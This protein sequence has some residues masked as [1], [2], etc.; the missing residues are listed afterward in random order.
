MKNSLM[1]FIAF[2][3]L[4][5]CSKHQE[6]KNIAITGIDSTLRPGDDFFKYVNGKWYDSVQIPASQAGVGV[7]MFMN[8]P[9]RM[10]LQE[11]LDSISQSKNEAGSIAQKVGDFYASGMDTVTIDKRGYTPIKPLLAKI[12]SITDLP[13]LLN[14]VANEEKV[15]NSSIIGFGVSP[16]EKNSSMNIA[17]IYQTGIGLPDRDY[18]FK[19]DSS[20]VAIQKAYKKYLATL[21]QQTGSDAK[22]AEKNANLVYDIDKQLAASHKTKVELRDVQANYNKIAVAALAKRNPNIDWTTFL[23]NLGAKTDSINVGQP[24][25]Y[26]ALNK[27]LKSIPINN[28]KIYLKANSLERYADDLSKS[29]ADASFEYTKVLS[30]QA[31]QKTRG[32]KMANVLDTYLGDALGELY[33]KK[34]FSE[35]AKKRMLVLVNNLQ[36]AY[37][38]RIDKLEWMSPITKQ[39]AK[40]KLA[41]MTKKIGYPD[42]WRDYSNVQVARNTYF[43]NMVSASKDAYQFQLAKLGKPVDKSE[44]FTTVPTVTA[45]NNPTANEIVFPAG[46]LQPPY[47]DNNADD[48]LNYGGIGMVIGHEITHTFDDQGAQYDKDGNLKNWWTKEDYAQFKSR[49]QQVINLYSTY[50]VLG[51]LHING[52]MTVG[53]NTADIAGLAVAY[54]AFKMTEQGKGNTKIDGYTPDQRFFI[55]LAKIWRVKMKDEFLRLWI[56][57]NPH[58]PPNWRVNGP[59]MNTTPFYEAFN[60]KPGD[61]MFLPKKDRITIW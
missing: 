40:E 51:D 9:Q 47:F 23:N 48:A 21:F 14:F 7:Y 26:D 15:S 61:K 4:T 1:L 50:T 29:F 34:Y 46:I 38:K 25:Y 57:N 37:A 39:K 54:D 22:E 45:Y 16:D 53:E 44:W 42:K 59:L 20:T 56:N 27:L 6:K 35:D 28:W 43:E 49:I 30:G 19:S 32:E 2:L 31:V 58:S 5:A 52:A 17:Q 18:Y 10:R 24:A 36:K 33:V 12:E 55:S 8:Y 3:A 60:V 11:I 13:S 41:A